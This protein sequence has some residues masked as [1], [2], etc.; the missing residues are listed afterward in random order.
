MY[1]R[2]YNIQRNPTD[3]SMDIINNGFNNR[4]Q[5]QAIKSNINKPKPIKY[6]PGVLGVSDVADIGILSAVSLGTGIAV[7]KPLLGAMGM[8]PAAVLGNFLYES[9]HKRAR[10]KLEQERANK[11]K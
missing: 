10:E 8:I 7:G 1:N 6:S 11:V 5:E 4:R 3:V 2:N 9:T